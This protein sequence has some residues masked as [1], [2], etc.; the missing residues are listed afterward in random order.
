MGFMQR[1]S[2]EQPV[3]GEI[4]GERSSWKWPSF[5]VKR[6]SLKPDGSKR[7]PQA[8]RFA[9]ADIQLPDERLRRLATL[10]LRGLVNEGLDRVALHHKE[11]GRVSAY[12]LLDESRVEITDAKGELIYDGPALG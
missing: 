7:E 4:V 6:S 8:R 12:V 9:A 10:A 1:D 5:P 11:A 3:T 2:G